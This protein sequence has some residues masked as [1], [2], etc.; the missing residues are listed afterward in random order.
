M[1]VRTNGRRAFFKF[2]ELWCKC[3]E[4]GRSGSITETSYPPESAHPHAEHGDRSTIDTFHR[5]G[6]GLAR[7][8]QREHVEQRQ[9]VIR[10]GDRQHRVAA[11][12]LVQ[13]ERLEVARR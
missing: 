11:P 13:G 8:A 7:P 5:E 3:S 12:G 2:G 10:R 9:I 4:S 1:L 6:D